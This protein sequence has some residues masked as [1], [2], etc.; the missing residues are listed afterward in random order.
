MKK[1]LVLFS[2]L[3]STCACPCDAKM[4]EGTSIQSSQISDKEITGYAQNYLDYLEKVGET[5]A[6]NVAN[7]PPPFNVNCRKTMN[8]EVVA[9]NATEFVNQLSGVR[10]AC[11][12]WKMDVL[13][14][15]PS[16]S[17]KSATLHYTIK[18]P[19]LGT[20]T[21]MKV[22]RFDDSGKVLEINEV[23]SPLKEEKKE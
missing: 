22:A 18:A 7:I 6:E 12:S 20:F 10:K 11:A 13:E 21:V 16:P 3:L 4:K 19:H 14:I 8:G 1:T 9:H 5:P 2:A 17:T 15:I 23:F